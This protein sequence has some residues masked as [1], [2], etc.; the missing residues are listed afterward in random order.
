MAIISHPEGQAVLKALMQMPNE[1][2]AFVQ[3]SLVSKFF[4]ELELSLT[5]QLEACANES[6]KLDIKTECVINKD[7]LLNLYMHTPYESVF[8]A[9][10]EQKHYELVFAIKRHTSGQILTFNIA[11]E[12][13]LCCGLRIFTQQA[14]P[15]VRSKVKTTPEFNAKLELLKY[16]NTE[17]L[18]KSAYCRFIAYRNFKNPL[19]TE[20][21]EA[22]GLDFINLSQDLLLLLQDAK[23]RQALVGALAQEAI[24]DIQALLAEPVW[25]SRPK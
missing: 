2:W 18:Q 7:T 25:F 16:T 20:A 8:C 4:S 5:S 21:N 24:S 9:T 19:E 22:Q 10:K 1:L 23:K 13:H 14:N 12:P 17:A 15:I 3:A 6:F 11:L